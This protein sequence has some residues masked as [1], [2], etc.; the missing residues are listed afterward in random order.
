MK[1]IFFGSDDFALSHLECLVRSPHVICA[2][3]TQPDR[4]KG[5]HLQ[6]SVSPIKEFALKHRIPLLQPD[7][8]DESSFIEQLKSYA[9][10]LFV[11]I[12]YGKIL[13]KGI[14]DL[15]KIFCINV[16]GSLL[17]KY[18]GAAPVNWAVINAEKTTGISIIKMNSRMDAG[19]IIAQKEITIE[20]EETAG[21]LREKMMRT[22]TEFLLETLTAIEEKIYRLIR[23]DE[24]KATFA[25][26]LKKDQGLIRWEDKADS[27][28]NLIRGLL[29]YPGAFTYYGP[30]RL[31]IL[32]A[33]VMKIDS[34]QFNPGQLIDIGADGL[35]VATGK[36]AL[37]IRQV[38]L[39][40]SKPMDSK[41]FLAGH[42]LG[43]GFRFGDK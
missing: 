21:Q 8:L 31:K 33:T 20:P 37:C 42:K 29:P 18:R 6:L 32:E 2:C 12:A 1:I 28:Y 40:G 35:V 5:R 41:S 7:R 14:L 17:P 38:H 30:K 13:P 36:D 39:E 34:T 23:Q 9:G 11:V 25:P 43:I 26:K 19:E 3:V 15:P 24:T 16:H 27:I 10:D 22:S 4:P